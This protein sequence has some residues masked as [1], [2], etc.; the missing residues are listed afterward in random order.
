VTCYPTRFGWRPQNHDR[1]D[2][3]PGAKHRAAEFGYRVEHLWYAEPGMTPERFRDILTVRGI[4]GLI[5]GRMPPTCDTLTLPW[6]HFSIVALGMT[7]RS[8]RLHHVTENHFDTAWQG[9]EQCR[10]RGYRRVGFVFSEANDSPE[11]G[12]RWL[13]AYSVQQLRFRAEDR[14]PICPGAPTDGA[15]F[16]SWFKATRPDAL[17]VTH[18]APVLEWLADAGL[19]VPRDVGLV[20]LQDSAERGVSGVCY[21]PATIGALAVELLIGLMHRNE[22]GLPASQHEVM[23]SGQWWEGTTLPMRRAPARVGVST[24]RPAAPMP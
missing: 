11:V 1:P 19:V 17:I 4:H 5:I 15:T 8:P 16:L 18:A 22:V 10:A 2:F 14:I 12:N 7:L 3:Y 21:D 24:G 20:E 6:E 13:G 9:M 23:L